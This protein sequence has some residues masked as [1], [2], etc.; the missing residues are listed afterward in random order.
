MPI[1]T[2]PPEKENIKRIIENINIRVRET[3][4]LKKGFS[5]YFEAGGL[6][7]FL[8]YY[9]EIHRVKQSPLAKQFFYETIEHLIDN[10]AM[11]PLVY[12]EDLTKYA[13]LG[14]LLEYLHKESALN[15]DLD[16]LLKN[17]DANLINAV[18]DLSEAKSL[19]LLGGVVS[20][21]LYYTLRFY[22][23][24]KKFGVFL[25][26]IVDLL[27][28]DAIKDNGMCAWT[29]IIDLSNNTIGYNLGIAHGIPG[30]ILFLRKMYLMNISRHKS[31]ILI[32]GAVNFLLSQMDSSP[33]SLVLF[34]D[35]CDLNYKGGKSRLAWCYGD[36]GIAYT[37]ILLSQLKEL[38]LTYLKGIAA[39]I[40]KK[41]TKRTDY[42]QTR[43]SDAGLCHGCIGV[44]HIYNRL[45]QITK[46]S[47][48]RRVALFWYNEGLSLFNESDLDYAGFRLPFFTSDDNHELVDD[49]NFSFLTGI[50][51]IGLGLLSSIYSIDPRW[52]LFL[53]LGE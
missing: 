11:V 17:L 20:I 18:C 50:S 19:D 27:F 29:S 52:D 35:V 4:L 31:E 37:F 43:I 9:D 24:P 34:S 15:A 51:G 30:I 22:S 7:L 28:R 21:G 33:D 16:Y 3:I 32:K 2:A 13:E 26:Q 40:L 53:L 39:N 14:S 12:T 6:C 45:Y 49:Y 8:S 44:A 23:N 1:I 25:E 41:T 36:L 5:V 46:E 48:L 42:V 47:I 38:N 10:S